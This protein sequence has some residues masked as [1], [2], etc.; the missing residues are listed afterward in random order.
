MIT[1]RP[2]R[3]GSFPRKYG[4]ENLGGEH[5]FFHVGG[6]WRPIMAG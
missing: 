2:C 6:N 3:M 5:M 1:D 4:Y